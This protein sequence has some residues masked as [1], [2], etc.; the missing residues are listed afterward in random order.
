MKRDETFKELNG[1][2]DRQAEKDRLD[3]SWV[4]LE[5][6]FDLVPSSHTESWIDFIGVE[7]NRIRLELIA[8]REAR[9]WGK[10]KNPKIVECTC[11]YSEVESERCFASVHKREST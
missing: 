2:I 10:F 6:A 8:M 1:L 7:L 9:G 3:R 5:R 11:G 4:A